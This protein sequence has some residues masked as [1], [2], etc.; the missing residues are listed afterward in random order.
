MVSVGFA[1]RREA[2]DLLQR[3]LILRGFKT[4]FVDRCGH[5]LRGIGFGVG[6][7][8][9]GLG[10]LFCRIQVCVSRQL[11][12]AFLALG[13]GDLSAA[14]AFGVQLLKHGVAWLDQGSRPKSRRG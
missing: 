8:A 1:N 6:K 13:L 10:G 9:A 4:V 5:D 11:D 2:F 14:C 7:H 12:R 3:D